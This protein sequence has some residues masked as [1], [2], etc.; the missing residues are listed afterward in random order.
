MSPVLKFIK[1]L[2]C[3]DEKYTFIIPLIAQSIELFNDIYFK[4]FKYLLLILKIPLK[5]LLY[6]NNKKSLLHSYF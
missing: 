5:H 3:H 1:A 2:C 4:K 6:L